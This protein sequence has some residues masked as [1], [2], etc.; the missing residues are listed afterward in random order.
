MRPKR[1]S[2]RGKK[3][4]SRKIC[5]LYCDGE[6]RAVVDVS[7]KS[8]QKMKNRFCHLYGYESTYIGGC[9]A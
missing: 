3:C 9:H 5:I 7:T 8:G 4:K 2:K 6:Q 1:K